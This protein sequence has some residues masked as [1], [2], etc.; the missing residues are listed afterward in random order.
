M[1]KRI[2][3]RDF[4]R[5]TSIAAGASAIAACAPAGSNAPAAEE[6]APEQAP[7]AYTGKLVIVSLGAL[8]TNQP[9]ITKIEEKFPGIKIDWKNFTSEKF[10]ELFAAAEVAGDQIDI[11]DLNGQDLRRYAVGKKLLDVGT[12]GIDTKRFRQVGLDTYTI[13]GKTWALPYGGIS[14]FPF[15]MNKKSLEKIGADKEPETYEDLKAM[16]PEFIKAG[17]APFVHQGKNIYMWPVW[18]FWAYGQTTG[19]KSVSYTYDTLQGKRKFTDPESVA[20]LEMLYRYAQDGMFNENVNSTD[21]DAAWQ[22]FSTGKAA[23]F[24]EHCWRIGFFRKN[25]KDLPDLGMSLI[26]PLRMVSDAGIKREL[27]GGTGDALGI[28]SKLDASRLEITKQIVDF[29]ILDENVKWKNDINGDPVSCNTNVEAS[30]DPNAIKYA[31]ECADVQTTYLDWFWPP[32]ITRSFQEQQQALV[33]GTAKPDQAAANIQSVF[34]QLVKD[35]YKF[36]M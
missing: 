11:M 9:L 19:N 25:E 22:M 5:Y 18:H 16:A 30:S 13:G 28:Y 6:A 27:P 10:T 32:E 23:F 21:G 3:R 8:D 15:L 26:A 33:A 34:D 29:I 36:E 14:G 35:G 1:E 4:L 2:N 12:F 17:I 20:A 31:K 24:Y 7:K